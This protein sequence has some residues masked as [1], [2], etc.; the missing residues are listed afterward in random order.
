MS[1]QASF[2]INRRDHSLARSL[3]S[4]GIKIFRN[5]KIMKI[6]IV[7]VIRSCGNGKVLGRPVSNCRVASRVMDMPLSEVKVQSPSPA[8]P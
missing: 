5:N 6:I 7:I 2:S 8:L 3:C 1:K 4:V